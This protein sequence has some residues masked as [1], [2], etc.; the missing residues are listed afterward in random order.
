MPR[1]A[2]P[3]QYPDELVER[4]RE[5]YIA[6]MTQAE[7][8]TEHGLSQK[9]VWN[10]M[11]RHNIPRRRAA[12]RHQSGSANAAWRGDAATYQAFHK[13]VEVARGTPQVCMRCGT[14]RADATYEWAN[15]SGNYADVGD[16]QRMCRSCHRRYDNARR[17]EVMP[18]A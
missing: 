10:L 5:Q 1:G 15:L 13:R 17:R 6:G 8:G 7:I 18:N 16:Y 11:R 9:V 14:T 2:R 12:K 3:K 4:V